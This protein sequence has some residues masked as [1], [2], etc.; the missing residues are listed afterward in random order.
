MLSSLVLKP[1]RAMASP[2]VWPWLNLPVF[3]AASHGFI[4]GEAWRRQR[5]SII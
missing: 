1:L 2:G 5:R 4:W 3:A